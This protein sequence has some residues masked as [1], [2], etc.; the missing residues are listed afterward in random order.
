[1][2]ELA[3]CGVVELVDAIRNRE[4]RVESSLSTT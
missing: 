4:F 2:D 1:M 3:F